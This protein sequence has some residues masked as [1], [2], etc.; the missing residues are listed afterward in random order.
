MSKKEE[1]GMTR[2]KNLDIPG[3]G[4]VLFAASTRAQRISISV[5]PPR[6]VRVA[7]PR[8][9]SLARAA[10]ALASRRNWVRNQLARMAEHAAEVAR[11][12]EM[13]HVPDPD[14]AAHHLR[15]R[16]MQLAAE[17]GFSHGRV[18]VRNQRT[19]WGSCSATG[20]ISLN[21][22]LAALPPELRDYVLLHE[23]VHT[24]VPNHQPEFW[25]SLEAVVPDAR[26]RRRRL[27]AYGPGLSG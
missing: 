21:I 14:R 15:T 22:K 26:E 24:R 9:V 7:V 1:G 17:H 18:T 6:R 16:L 27:R 25:Q 3:I 19:R 10:A 23:L 13:L 4:P 12:K 5:R 8:G 11:L 20:N 2:D